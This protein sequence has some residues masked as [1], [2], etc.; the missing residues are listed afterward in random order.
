[1]ELTDAQK[2]IVEQDG[3]CVVLA[4]PGSGKTF[5]ISEKIRRILLG[6]ELRDYQGVIAISYTRK[7]AKNLKDRVFANIPFSRSSFFG[8]ID[9][10]CFSEVIY[11]FLSHIW[12]SKKKEISIK[13]LNDCD[14]DNQELFLWIKEKR[15][16]YSIAEE[17]WAQ[18]WELYYEEGFVLVEALELLACKIIKESTACRN[19]LKA[20]YRYIFID[21]YQDADIYT[22]ILFDELVSLGLV[23]IAVGDAK[24][25]IFGYDKKDSKYLQALVERG[26]FH[27]F[28]LDK[29]FRCSP[30]IINYS[31]RLMDADSTLL[32]AS[33]IDVHLVRIEG[34][35]SA[36][37]KFLSSNIKDCCKRYHVKKLSDVAVLAKTNK[38]LDLIASHLSLP[39]RMY[40]TTGLDNDSNVCSS[41]YAALL[42]F[43]Y[44]SNMTFL[45]T[46]EDFVDIEMLTRYDHKRVL[47]L[48][49]QLRS[50]SLPDDVELFVGYCTELA[51]IILPNASNDVSSA[52]LRKVI[53][54]KKSLES[55][56]PLNDNEVNLMTL[57][58]SKGLE[59]DLVFHLN[60]HEWVIP[61][62]NIINGDFNNCYY[63]SWQQD[64]DL[65]Y[66]GITRA[67]KACYMIVNNR[68]LGSKGYIVAGRDSEFL[69]LN[70][71]GKL[72]NEF[73]FQ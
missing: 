23:G 51:D 62:K 12:G 25:S 14:K 45:E 6:D 72:R 19:Y 52:I 35:E 56:R 13:S 28:P 34:E 4:A 26:D 64:L 20:R 49:V 57:H 22:S 66:V 3:N 32:P 63:P 33:Q 67:K 38:Y 17:E 5:V 41:F 43:Y 11:P 31:N 30:S 42:R 65:H 70:G 7:A 73:Y 24:Q 47:Q 68:R 40:N 29:N 50:L 36:V 54:D 9:G 58:K 48:K 27:Y 53:G 8:T 71:I 16:I 59:F 39:Y 61:S 1:M 21:E 18:L 44:D 46:L 55:Y 2:I 10:F 37:S 60:L 69:S 15:D